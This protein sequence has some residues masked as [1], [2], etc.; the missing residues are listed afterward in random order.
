MMR[1]GSVIVLLG[2]LA[3]GALLVLQYQQWDQR[4]QAAQAQVV[5]FSN[6][7]QVAWAKVAERDRILATLETNLN[8]RTDELVAASAQLVQAKSDLAQTRT[9]LARARTELAS[10]QEALRAAQTDLEAKTAR[11]TSLEAVAEA[12][13]WQM[14]QLTNSLGSLEAQIAEVQGKLARSEGNRDFLVKELKRLQQEKAA[15]L[16]RFNDLA[17]LRAQIARLR[18]EAAVNRRLTWMQQGVYERREMKGAQGLVSPVQAPPPRGATLNVE[19]DR[20]GSARVVAE[21]NSP[22]PNP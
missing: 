17:A 7:A 18:A 3:L 13:G 20:G 16:A 11:L 15:L 4:V 1:F 19:M 8:S 6:A 5:H 14:G 12:L 2:A 9:E 21:T 22:S 10:V